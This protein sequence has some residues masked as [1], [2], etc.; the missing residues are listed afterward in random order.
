[1]H[2]SVA[3]GPCLYSGT[4]I[5]GTTKRDDGMVFGFV[6]RKKLISVDVSAF[7]IRIFAESLGFTQ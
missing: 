6:P 5:F 7:S 2:L 4:G 1:M 3:E